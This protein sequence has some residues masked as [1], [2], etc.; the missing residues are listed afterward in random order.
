MKF[1]KNTK[2]GLSLLLSALLVLS[3]VTVGFGGLAASAAGNTIYVATTGSD[4]S[5]NGSAS[6]PFAS[7]K[8]ALSVAGTGD[9]IELAGGTYYVDETLNIS[10]KSGITIM[11]KSGEKAVLSGGYNVTG[12]ANAT[13]NG[14][15]CLAADIP[16]DIVKDMDGVYTLYNAA[17]DMLVNSRFPDT[18]YRYVKAAGSSIVDGKIRSFIGNAEDVDWLAEEVL[19]RALVRVEHKWVSE[20]SVVANYTPGGH[21]VTLEKVNQNCE[22]GD[23]FYFENVKHGFDKAGEWYYDYAA[24]KL[25]YIPKSGESTSNLNLILGKEEKLLNITGSTNINVQNIGFANTNWTYKNGLGQAAIGSESCVTV[26]SSS[27]VNFAGCSFDNIGNTA[28]SFGHN[29][30]DGRCTNCSVTG[31]YFKNIGNSA[32]FVGAGD[33]ADTCCDHITISDNLVAGYGKMLHEAVG[34]FITKANNCTISSNEVRDGDYTGI[35]VGWNWGYMD[36]VTHD[37]HVVSNLI[38][39]IGHAALCDMGG[40]YFLGKQAGSTIDSNVIFGVEHLDSATTSGAWGIYLDEGSSGVTV[41]NNIVHDCGEGFHQHYGQNNTVSNNIFAFNH[42]GQV[43]SSNNCAPLASGE[44]DQS[45]EK[46]LWIK[47]SNGNQFTLENNILVADNGYMYSQLKNE[48]YFSDDYNTYWDY[49]SS[50]GANVRSQGSM[51]E[52]AEIQNSNTSNDYSHGNFSNPNFTNW[53]TRDFTFTSVPAGFTAI[54]VANVGSFTYGSAARYAA[55]KQNTLNENYHYEGANYDAYVAACES[56]DATAIATAYNTLVGGSYTITY[57]ANG[58]TCGEASKTYTGVS[59]ITLPNATKDGYRLVGW[60]RPDGKIYGAGTYYAGAG[61]YTMTAVYEKSRPVVTASQLNGYC[62]VYFDNV[63]NFKTMFP[64]D[65]VAANTFGGHGVG[66]LVVDYGSNSLS[67][68]VVNR[69]TSTEHG[70][71]TTHTQGLALDPNLEYKISYDVYIDGK[72][73]DNGRMTMFFYNEANVYTEGLKY[74]AT[75]YE[76]IASGSTFRVPADGYVYVS[77]RPGTYDI[78]DGQTVEYRNIR[79]YQNGSYKNRTTPEFIVKAVPNNTAMGDMPTESCYGNYFD[80]WKNSNGKIG[81]DYVVTGGMSLDPNWIYVKIEDQPGE[82]PNLGMRVSVPESVYLA[83]SSVNFQYY[84]DNTMPDSADG[85]LTLNASAADTTGDIYFRCPAYA[86]KTIRAALWDT[87]TMNNAEDTEICGV[88]ITLNANGYGHGTIDT[89]NKGVHASLSAAGSRELKWIFYEGTDTNNVITTAYTTAYAPNLVSL[90]SFVQNTNTNR[91]YDSRKS[92][93]QMYFWVTGIHSTKNTDHNGGNTI[94]GSYYTTLDGLTE[95]YS[96]TSGTDTGSGKIGNSYSNDSS[97]GKTAKATSSYGVVNFDSSRYTNLNQIPNVRLGCWINAVPVSDSNAIYGWWNIYDVTSLNTPN[98][99]NGEGSTQAGSLSSDGTFLYGSQTVDKN[100]SG[101]SNTITNGFVKLTNTTGSEWNHTL[102]LTSSATISAKAQI[103]AKNSYDLKNGKDYISNGG[104]QNNLITIPINKSTLRSKVAEA[105]NCGLASDTASTYYTDYVN[106]CKILGKPDAPATGDNSVEAAY[107]ALSTAVTNYRPSGTVTVN[108]KIGD[109][110]NS[111]ASASYTTPSKITAYAKV[112]DGYALD[113]ATVNGAAAT[114]QNGDRVIYDVEGTTSAVTVNFNYVTAKFN[115]T[116]IDGDTTV[117][118]KSVNYG[119]QYQNLG[120][121]DNYTPNKPGYTFI[122]WNTERGLIEPGNTN[123]LKS[124]IKVYA[125]YKVTDCDVYYNLNYDGIGVN[126]LQAPEMLAAASSGLSCAY[127]PVTG[128]LTL[129]GTLTGSADYLIKFPIDTANLS[130]GTY[131]LVLE[132][133]GGER[134]EAGYGYYDGGDHSVEVRDGCLVFEALKEDGSRLGSTGS[135]R[136]HAD[137]FGNPVVEKDMTFTA[138]KLSMTDSIALWAVVNSAPNLKVTNYQ[139]KVKLQQK[140]TPAVAVGSPYAQTVK[141]GDVV[142]EDNKPV[143]VRTG[144]TF[145][146]WYQDAACTN[147]WN[148]S[149]N[150][151]TNATTTLYAKWTGNAYRVGYDN[152]YFSEGYTGA[153]ADANYS[154]YDYDATTKTVTMT[155]KSHDGD[156]ENTASS[157]AAIAVKPN[158]EYIISGDFTVSGATDTSSQIY[159]FYSGTGCTVAHSDAQP[160]TIINID[161]TDCAAGAA[162]YT[163]AFKNG[164]H[165]Y[166]IRTPENCTSITLRVDCNNSSTTTAGT[167]TVSNIRVIERTSPRMGASYSAPEKDVTFDAAYG[168][169]IAPTRVGYTF[170]GWYK[171]A[172]LTNK[173]TASTVVTTAANH[174]LYSNWTPI[175]YEIDYENMEGA[176]VSGNPSTYTIETNSITLNNPTKAGYIF[177]GW[178]LYV[179]PETGKFG[180]GSKSGDPAVIGKGSYGDVAAIASWTSIATD[181]TFVVDSVNPVKLNVLANDMTGTTVKSVSGS[182]DDFTVSVSDNKILFTPNTVLTGKVTFT[183]T[184]QNNGSERVTTVKVVPA[185]SLY[186]EEDFVTFADDAPDLVW[187]TV[188]EA[189]SAEIR[190]ILAAGNAKGDAYGATA[191]YTAANSATYSMGTAKMLEIDS[192]K[193]ANRNEAAYA[194]FT[195]TGT[196]FDVNTLLSVQTGYFTIYITDDLTDTDFE[197]ADAYFAYLDNGY[198]YGQLFCKDGALTLDKTGEALYT[199]GTGKSYKLSGKEYFTQGSSEDLAYGWLTPSDPDSVTPIYQSPA[200]TMTGLDYGTYNVRIAPMFVTKS[201]LNKDKKCE[202]YVDSVRIYNPI[203][204]ATTDEDV[205]A[206]Y[207]ADNEYDGKYQNIRDILKSAQD[208]G[209]SLLEELAQTQKAIGIAFLGVV[210]VDGGDA[211]SLLAQ[212]EKVGAKNEVYLAEGNTIAFKIATGSSTRPSKFSLGMKLLYGSGTATIEV[213]DVEYSTDLSTEQYRNLNGA[214]TWEEDGANGYVAKVVITN[215][216]SVPV[217]LTNIRYSYDKAAP[218]PANAP[219]RMKRAALDDGTHDLTFFFDA[220]LLQTVA[221]AATAA[222]GD[223]P[224][225]YKNVSVN[226][227]SSEI[228]LG[229]STDITVECPEIITKITVDGEEF[230]D[231]ELTENGKVFTVTVTPEEV[232]SHEY[233]IVLYDADGYH[234]REILTPVCKVNEPKIDMSKVTAVWSADTVNLGDTATLTV[235]APANVSAVKVGATTV[236]EFTTNADGTRT[237]IYTVTPMAIGEYSYTLN[238][239]E[240]NGYVSGTVYAPLL[241]VTAYVVPTE[242]VNIGWDKESYEPGDTATLT[243]TAPA[244]VTKVTVDGTDITDFTDN[245]DGTR[246]FTYTVDTTGEGKLACTVRLTDEN[247]MVSEAVASGTAEVKT[248]ETGTAEPGTDEPQP[249]KLTF[250]QKLIRFFKNLFTK[251]ITLIK[252]AF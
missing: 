220:E 144:Y 221:A 43:R 95:G 173:V 230:T 48:S 14:Q 44:S 66:N 20:T 150:T 172:A 205:I 132:E 92:R 36:T 70:S 124:D 62:I 164:S 40:I 154:T 5:G 87:A 7:L 142:G 223:I 211:A 16:Y 83:P 159:C 222:Q 186:Y 12:W 152:L 170:E 140:E 101:F 50:I 53:Q 189:K 64:Q 147:A 75:Y 25:Y 88:E 67:Y 84:V 47:K 119:T 171:E 125:V 247:G 233:S 197:D 174:T 166:V 209:S 182:C 10:N 91:L 207:K 176:T 219:S 105:V 135:E 114:I 38:Y 184:A 227:T 136:V 69:G 63:A 13:L 96:V 185:D 133:I 177:N 115:V 54:S 162:V 52:K 2:R 126:L 225:E 145:G 116:Y 21:E 61:S 89:T 178:T 244:T 45:G 15:S 31:S 42:V 22:S 198:E 212:Y 180:S 216:S 30:G 79:I 139:V 90:S 134:Y 24:C 195:F 37:N 246:T 106:A 123:Q 76:N 41:Q 193:N 32:V 122:G 46:K 57:N 153:D 39:N 160:T 217:S 94:T 56:G 169:L 19:N 103:A 239:E 71:F 243:V 111:T 240:I 156:N 35:S 104:I 1:L 100:T 188:G 129:D 201:D 249:E 181:D 81:E 146:G 235:T 149:S 158:T 4:V 130:A 9:T 23:N 218:A 242:G 215:T 202:F 234:S 29:N 232:G 183:Y 229:E 141:Y 82:Q 118:T 86:N 191:A 168:T 98:Y 8:L 59:T 213:N 157:K 187:E 241:K 155:H 80:G 163:P 28:L 109:T 51:T 194:Q 167:V 121:P 26:K 34:I 127:D 208:L 49:N 85:A 148:F 110:V 60:Q 72:K 210:G 238:C 138:E 214:L 73:S 93:I 248:A 190:E 252:E 99:G 117:Q 236:S 137:F 199:K 78:D 165:Y 58:G 3:T 131:T 11:S 245:G 113:S 77:I 65:S 18:G 237:F 224:M 206:A 196:G 192:T 112:I 151:V 97:T 175:E 55:I 128:I 27:G 108:Y 17:G 203:D 204:P 33:A 143:P 68:T 200:I 226:W 250:I 161:G 107:N 102:N 120:A 179:N 228:E 231:C 6:K 251:I 74:H